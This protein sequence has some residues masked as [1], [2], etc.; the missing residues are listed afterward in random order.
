ML[1]LGNDHS[2][3]KPTSPL[4]QWLRTTLDLKDARLQAR[5]RGNHLHILCESDPCP[6]QLTLLSRLLPALQQTPLTQLFPSN[7]PPI[8]QL[9]LYG[10]RPGQ[11]RPDWGAAIHPDH[12]DQQIAHL[13][14]ML[15]AEARTPTAVVGS[16]PPA[17]PTTTPQGQLSQANL[18]RAKQGDLGAIARYLSSTLSHLGVSVQAS[19]KMLP[20]VA[21]PDLARGHHS[22][23]EPQRQR[24]WICC[25]AHY[26]PA[27]ATIAE[28]VAQKLRDLSLEGFRDAIVVFQV[29]GESQPDW[30]LRVDLTPAEMMLRE[31]AR[32]G[33]VGA[34]TRL[35]NQALAPLD[36]EVATAS[37]QASTLHLFCNHRTQAETTAPD[38]AAL[39]AQ[40][41]PLLEQLAPQGI[42]S[43]MLYGQLLGQE[44]PVWVHWVDLPASQNPALAEPPL[45]LAHQG[46]WGAIAFLLNRLLNP[47]L[48]SQLATGGIRV[49][50]SPRK[51]LLHVMTDGPVCPDQQQV[52]P[53]VARFLRELNLPNLAGVRVYGRRAGQ[54]RPRWS[55]ASD[56]VQRDRLVPEPAPEFAATAAYV[57]DLLGAPGELVPHPDAKPPDLQ[58]A[59][60]RFWHRTDAW[61]HNALVRSH[62][63][64]PTAHHQAPPASL[65]LPKLAVVWG[66]AGLLLALQVDWAL[67]WMARSP[68]A[69]GTDV[70][71]ASQP[72]PTAPAAPT[73]AM[74]TPAPAPSTPLPTLSLNR[75]GEAKPGPFNERGFT[76]PAT[77]A[78]TP[79]ANPPVSSAPTDLPFTPP[80]AAS[81]TAAAAVLASESPYPTFNSR[82]LNE[83]LLLY[84]EHLK[85][86]GPPDVLV[87]GSSRALR[88]VDPAALQKVLSDLGYADVTVFNFGVNGAT[89]QVVDLILRG[90]LKPEQLPRLILWAD[91]ARAFNSG[92]V[93]VTYN[94]IAVSE[95]YRQL[96]Q[97]TLARP[98]LQPLPPPDTRA[99]TT[100]A[101]LPNAG[102]GGSLSASY[103]NIDRWLSN[104]LGSLSAS[105]GE[106]DR[107]KNLVQQWLTAILPA[108]APPPQRP[109]IPLPLVP[110]Q[111]DPNTT[112]SLSEEGRDLVDFSGFWPVALRFNPA[113]YFQEYARVAGQYDSDYQDF[114][115]EG[116][117]AN[118]FRTL[119]E[120]TRSRNIPV[121]FA[122][123]PLTDQYLDNYRRDR[124]NEFRQFMLREALNQPG[125]IFRDLGEVWQKEYDYFSDPSHL[126]RYGA[127]QVSRRLAQ[128]P[129]IPWGAIAQ[130]TGPSSNVP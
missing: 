65:P 121:V 7:H 36:L 55:Y 50:L 99:A 108:A 95:G 76:R 83:K 71:A 21:H 66:A 26:S 34:I 79:A 81:Q 29:T 106:R 68:Q 6:T 25:E 56:F 103:G 129:M 61:V 11:A 44:A 123:L 107:A 39:R 120:F 130:E 80:S 84:T 63:F 115:I 72:R 87:V 67:G 32:W 23:A 98:D 5:V 35:L 93:D 62:L 92:A 52:G 24:L 58:T 100:V 40:V 105:F 37:Q 73:P 96:I 126:N 45:A 89:A 119:L 30:M 33:D 109:L 111:P 75:S 43:A 10:R 41:E 114:R 31:W 9:F 110:G 77:P 38:Q 113:T 125:F 69:T 124:E 90:I 18:H 94:G 59:W 91:G 22:S 16:V 118:A 8:Y 117:Q 27:P 13:N 74:A 112:Q 42:H 102:V 116:N 60:K 47:D 104:R 3:A 49:Q 19:A 48:T 17:E 1:N 14:A 12:L 82:Q 85:Q 15:V 20:Y 2:P 70:A 4:I 28:P 46:N 64:I 57:G 128:D 101:S 54:T 122:N 78:P 53:T 51:D 97:G 86:F 88:G 127:Y